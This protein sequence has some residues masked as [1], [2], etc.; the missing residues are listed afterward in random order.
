MRTQEQYPKGTDITGKYAKH[1]VALVVKQTMHF[2]DN[3]LTEF[4]STNEMGRILGYKIRFDHTIFSK[5]RK[6]ASKIVKELYEFLVY[7]RMKEKRIRL[8]VIDSTD[9][10]AFSPNDKD[11]KYGHR[12]PSKREQRT[13]KDS[14]KTLFFGYKLHAIA[15]A[16]TKVPIAVEIAPANRHDKTFFHRLYAIAKKTFHIHMVPDSKL[17]AD[18]GYDST[19]IYQELRH[20]NVK[21]VIAING[22]GFYKSSVPKDPE[23]GR[24]WA[25]E[26]VFSRLKEVFGLSKNRFVGIQKVAVH[27][28]SCLIAYIVKYV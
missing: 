14:A 16:E 27:I 1:I 13:M 3:E 10:Q 22:R 15:D 11:A 26:R 2:T 9:I 12:T 20:D 19:D 7:R 23:Y 6:T 17:L 25:V 24:R 5:V 21:P 18:A 4:L 8:T 28:Y